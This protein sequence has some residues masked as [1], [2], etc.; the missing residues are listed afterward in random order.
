MHPEVEQELAHV[1]LTELLAYQFASPVRWIETQDVLFKQFNVERVVEVGPSPTLAGMAQRTLKSKY[2]SYDA[3]LSLQREILCYSKDQKDIYYLADEADEAP[4]PAGDAA[5]AAAAAATTAAAAAPVAAAAPS[6]PV[7]KVEDAPVKAQEIL[8]ALV[9]H[10]LK[11]TPEQVPLSKAIKDLVGGKSTIQNEILGD[12][13]KEFGAT[14]EKPEDTPLGELAESFQASFDGKL[15]KQSSSLI[16]R[17]MSSKMPGG[18]SLTSARSYLD[19]RWGLAAGRQDSVLLVALMNEPKNRLGS[20]AEAKAYLDEQTQKYAASAGLNL[21]A[22]A[23]GAEGGNGGGA[24]IDSAAFDALTKDQRYLVQQQLELFANYLK[25]DLRQGSKVAAAQKEAMDILQAELDLWNSEHGEVYAEGIKPAFSALKARVYDSYWNWAR[26]DSLSMYFDI[27][28]GRLSTVDREIMAK[29]IHLMNRTNHNLIDYMQYHM[30]HVPVHKGAT[31][32]LAKQLGLQLLENCKETLTEAPVYKDVSYPTGPQTTIDVKGNI[33]Y[34]EVPRPNVRKLEQYVHEMA[35]GGELTRDPTFVGEGVQGELKKLYSQISALAKTQT[36]STLDIEALYSDLVAKISQAEDDS[37]SVVENK[38]VSA[39]ITPGTLP[40]LHIKKKTELGAWNY[41]SQ[42]TATYLDGLEVAAR[43]GLTF[44]G[45][46]ALITGAGAGSIGASI[47]QGMISGGCKVIVTTSRY[48]RKVTEYYQSLYTKFGAKGSTLI[49]VPFNQGSKKDVDELVSFI[50]NDPK[51]GGLG[52]DLDFVVPFAALPENGIELEH[53]DSKSELAHRIMLTNLLRLLGNVKKQKVA[54]SYE[55]RPAQVMLPLSPNH[56]NFGS[57]GLYSESKI[58][59]ETLFNR[60]HTE[61]WGSY[62]TIVGVVIGWTRGTGLMS[63]NN[64]TAEGLEQLGVR[65][66]SQTEMAFS[67]MGLMTKDIVRLAQN[68][69]VWADLNGGFQY[70]PDLKGVVGKIRRDIVETSE[71]RRAV[72]QETAIEQKVV[73]GP[74]ADLPYQK[75]EVKPRA[76]LK[77]DFPTLKS[78]SEVKELSPAGD[79]L[80][81]LLDLSSVIVVT[82]FAEVGPWGNARTRWDMEANG[83]FSLEGAIE[84]AWIMGLIKH[85]NGPLP[86]MPQYSGWIDTKTKQPVDDRDIKTKYEDYLLEHAGIRLIEPELFNGYDP[87]KKTFL[88]EVIVEHDLEP[89]EASKESAEQFAL[90]QGA[91]VEIFAVPESDQWTVRLLKGSK[92]LIPKALKFDRLVAGQIP[93]GWDARRYGIPEDICDQ[94]DPITLYALVSTVEALLASGITDPYE[95]YKYVHVSEVGNCSG[96][97]MGGI[98]ALRGM[99]KDRFMDKPVQNDILQESFINT[100]SAWVNM[101]LLSA[102]G[103]IKTPVGACAT[104][105]E[106]VDIGCETILSGKARICLVGGYDDFQE[107]SSQEF[108][109]MNATS[110]AETEITHGRTPAEMSRPIT[111]TRSGFME[112]QGAGTQVLMAADLAIAMGVPIYCI[113]G[114]VNTATDKIGRS[115]PAPGKGILTTA[116]EHQTLKHANPLLNIKYRK[117]QLDSRLRDIKRWSEG[118]MEAI[119]ME[120][121]DVSDADRESFIQE[122]SAHIASQ[123]ERMIREAKNSWGNAFYKQDARIS[124]IRGAL[125]TYGLTIDDISVASFHGTSTKANE[126][127]ETTTVNAMLEHLGRTRGNPVYGIFQKYLTGHPKGA[128]GAWMLNG[129]IQ[130]L[131]SGIIPGNRNADN[132]DAYFEQCQHVVFPS[133]SMQTDGLKA[134]SVTSFGFGQKG[135]QAIVIHPDYLYAALTPSEYSEYASRVGQRYK[136]AYR[137]YHNAIAEES[138]F[139]A[140][141]KAP[142]AAELEQEVYLDPLVRVHQNED[143]EQYSFNAKDLASSA[144]VKDS[145]KDTAKVLANLTSQVSGSGKNVGVDVEAISAINIDNDTFLDRNFTANEQAYCFKAPSP[146]SSF[147]GTWSAKE[148][149]FKSLGV[150]SQGGG[151]ELKSIE[152][153]RDGNG[154]PVVV[155]H[156]AA[157]D[158]ASAKGISTVK[159]SISHDDSQAV[160]V[161][162]AE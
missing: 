12:L 20:E 2:E 60:W 105:V 75:V 135:A 103:P 97:G 56:G 131:N 128:A 70:I 138:M 137:Y 155:L 61:S 65:T 94:V 129:A 121:E 18:F 59:L 42:T 86:G 33:V 41:D 99:F 117:R 83:V 159:V 28:F 31:Y 107:E 124:P 19:S 63:A 154:A 7:A 95:F 93:T 37:K 113:V 156:G 96:S 6:G 35:C 132:V 148:A 72:A 69:P 104:A 118:E 32:E 81:G 49:V 142:Y 139:Q 51:N 111:S 22:P 54:H 106:S 126:K 144:F 133:R 110:N 125:A 145:H 114:Y 130:C 74:H 53:I 134:A 119:D 153:T 62:L 64:I 78:Y 136:K 73:N 71:I 26:Q 29:C 157:K 160:A 57:D 102:S 34:N 146:Q 149:V 161:A 84:M 123:S 76:N 30:D 48:S 143:T 98:T 82:G 100:M 91:N 140:K 15:G 55:T 122:R 16:A 79:A 58:S 80:E 158:A 21:S 11:K 1:L 127:N 92:L 24:V 27:V 120:L 152:I 150:K 68:S 89:F 43:D 44:Q 46:T 36:G 45:K 147:A 3:A 9:A 52:W 162:V 38:A 116:R 101:L 115:V 25:Q 10:K 77:F 151:A 40:F 85:H 88:Q 47:L 87:K 141:D 112:A 67:I 8:H 39:S 17:L 4:A 109:N 14:P 23:G 50:Y 5:P 108:A 13:G 90:E 66:F